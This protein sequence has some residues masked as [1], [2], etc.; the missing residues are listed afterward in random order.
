V[1]IGGTEFLRELAFLKQIFGAEFDPAQY[2][3]LLFG[4]AMVLMIVWKPRGFIG[5]REPTVALGKRKAIDAT[6]VREGHG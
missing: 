2:R 4:F 1:I 6:L 3:M 5:T